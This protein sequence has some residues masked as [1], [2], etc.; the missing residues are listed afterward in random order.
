[1]KPPSLALFQDPLVSSLVALALVAE[2]RAGQ[3]AGPSKDALRM[4][5]PATMPSGTTVEA[6]WP[7]PTAADWEK[8]CLVPWQRSFAD[9][10]RV[11]AET[12]KPILVCVN[13]DGEPASE[14]FAGIRYRSA[15]TAALLAPYVCLPASVYRHTE[16]D[17]DERGARVPCPRLGTVTCGEH[18]A[19][20][21]ALYERY[22]EGTRVAPRHIMLEL[23]GSESYDVYYSWDTASV[24]TAFR[25]GVEGRGT[26]PPR[27]SDL[28]LAERSA[29]ADVVDRVALE[30]AYVR[31]SRAERR[32]LLEATRVNAG[33]DQVDLLRLA[34]FGLDVELA[35]LARQSLAQSTSEAAVD[36]IAE[37]L[38]LPMDAAERAELLAAA[39]RLA[40]QFPR[41]GTLV[42]V[43]QGLAGASK[44]I[45]LRG[46]TA[47]LQAEYRTTAGARAAPV[48]SRAAEVDARPEDAGARLAFAE[49]LLARA[50]DPAVERDFAALL[51]EDA[52]NAALEAEQLGAKGWRLDV[53]LAVTAAAR[54]DE[55]A[56]VARAV[57]AV[58]G[59]MPKP[60]AGAEGFREDSLVEVLALFAKG[61]QRAIAKA[62]RERKPWPGEWLADVHATYAVLVQHP[63]GTDVNVADCTDFLGWLGASGRAAEALERGLARFPESWLL[64]QRLRARTLWESG[65]DGL[66]ST[67][68]RMLAREER[69]PALDWFAGFASI[70]AAE[71]HRRAGAAEKAL[72]AYER[73]VAHYQRDVERNPGHSESA[74][75]YV[76]LAE[77]GRA[78]I[79]LERGELERAVGEL[80]A[81]FERS[82]RASATFDGLGIAPIDTARMLLARCE[83]EGRAELAA[84]M[85]AG[86]DALDPALLDLPDLQRGVP[87][88]AARAGDRRR[89]PPREGGG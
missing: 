44:W 39:E 42:A 11:S 10:L 85:Q 71:S 46:W 23:D 75:H 16:R 52:R 49:S 22:F 51:G 33:V 25:K 55:E 59:G 87:N 7:A 73:A 79:A 3:Q 38:K 8:P 86:L 82:P 69:S 29:S 77:A 36:L 74:D 28:P 67:Y 61:R 1:M 62:Y 12:G 24:F 70:V 43:H 83:D 40:Q 47:D 45:D 78:K 2:P 9:A 27:S 63:L 14:H 15:D 20:E 41:A 30:Q 66:E 48:E 80:V 88:E 89:R 13:M 6:M 72:A 68:E 58:E 65:P 34:I 56:A 18:I 21:T 84:R 37:A 50:Q 5:S 19:A 32:S 81:S 4:G 53:V 26:R 35:R 60:G 54:G 17:Y 64:H 76:A 57:A 31:G